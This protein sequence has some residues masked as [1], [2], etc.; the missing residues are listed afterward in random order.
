MLIS[1]EY[2]INIK[3]HEFIIKIY[4][5]NTRFNN[6]GILEM[7]TLHVDNIEMYKDTF[8]KEKSLNFLLSNF[9]NELSYISHEKIDRIFCFYLSTGCIL[10][11]DNDYNIFI[12]WITE[13]LTNKN[14][15]R[16]HKINRIKNRLLPTINI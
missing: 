11:T 16:L 8:G 5:K 13:C 2:K 12:N 14:I 1:E 7:I 6:E 9:D 3:N 15:K 4:D 10:L